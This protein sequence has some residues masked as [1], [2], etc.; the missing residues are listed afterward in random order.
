MYY[1][2]ITIEG[3]S[4]EKVCEI[5]IWEVSF[6][7]NLFSKKIFSGQQHNSKILSFLLSIYVFF[8]K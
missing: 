5:T 3:Q 8:S 7:L 6:G 1:K 4:Y 2:M